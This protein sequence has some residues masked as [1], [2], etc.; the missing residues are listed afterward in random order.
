MKKQ[1]SNNLIMAIIMIA[2]GILFII[3][4]AGVISIAMTVFGVALLVVAV[5]D[6]LNKDWVP[7]VVKAVLGVAVILFGWL[8]VDIARI[9]LAVVL[10]IYGVLQVIEACKNLKKNKS[11]LSKILI[12]VE[13]VVIVAIAVCL[14]F[15]INI[16]FIIAG[17]F[18]LVEGILG[19]IK[20]LK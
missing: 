11:L 4:K 16:L 13:P 8:L 14:F 6:L 5:L 7:C 1:L 2:L 3:F 9:V 20:A 18:F 10:L 19:L 15:N 17:V 12:F